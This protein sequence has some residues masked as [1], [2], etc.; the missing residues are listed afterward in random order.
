MSRPCR[1]G[2]AGAGVPPAHRDHPYPV[3]GPAGP[4]V[5]RPGGQVRSRH[6]RRRLLACVGNGSTHADDGPQQ[7]GAMTATTDVLDLVQRWAAA[8]QGNDA[9]ALEGL[10]ADD[11]MGGGTMAPRRWWSGCWTRRPVSRGAT[12]PAGSASPWSPPDPPTAGCWPPPTSGCCRLPPAHP[13]S[14][15]R[16]WSTARRRMASGFEELEDRQG[17]SRVGEPLAVAERPAD[18]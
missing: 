3:P 5:G 6:G 1:P 14:D 18:L 13:P 17:Y 10:L 4:I 11:F 12:T 16:G 8:E 7:G 9:Q 15:G 2:A